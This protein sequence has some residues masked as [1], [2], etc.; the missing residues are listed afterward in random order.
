LVVFAHGS[1]S[2]RRSER[3]R[4]VAEYLNERNF[5]TLLFDL[6]TAEEAVDARTRQHRFDI[7]LLI[8]AAQRPAVHAVVSRGGRP[9]LAGSGSARTCR[10]ARRDLVLITLGPARA[11]HSSRAELR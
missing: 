6:L 11:A 7:G 4:L 8:T 9:D 1:G 5:G 10:G 2:S 3:D